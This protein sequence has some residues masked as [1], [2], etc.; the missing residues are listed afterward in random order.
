MMLKQSLFYILASIIIIIFATQAHQLIVYINKF[1]LYINYKLSPLFASLE[2]YGN[3]R[4]VILLT[5]IPIV[6]TGIPALIYRLIKGK[7]LPHFLAITWCVWL[8]I[9]LS[10]ILN[11]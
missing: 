1:Y 3:L 9:V 11:H 6:L 7:T 8:V 4:K 5:L 2:V 10:Y